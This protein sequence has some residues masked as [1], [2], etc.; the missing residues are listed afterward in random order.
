MLKNISQ[1]EIA[2]NN[3]TFR[4]YTEMN[5]P[6]PDIKE[7]LFQF[8]RFVGQIEEQTKIMQKSAEEKHAD[9]PQQEQPKE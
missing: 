8:L 5:A 4:F 3:F 6:L 7:A 1:L 9:M 2:I